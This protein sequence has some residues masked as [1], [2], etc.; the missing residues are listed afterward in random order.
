M[1]TQR[2]TVSDWWRGMLLLPWP[3]I[4]HRQIPPQLCIEFE[5][6]FE[7]QKLLG[8]TMDFS[9]P[10]DLFTASWRRKKEKRKEKRVSGP[11]T[12]VSVI[13]INGLN[14]S[15]IFKNSTINFNFWG[16]KIKSPLLELQNWT[17]KS[18]IKKNATWTWKGKGKFFVITFHYC[19]LT[20][21]LQQRQHDTS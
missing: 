7:N 3:P 2:R 15:R 20:S 8:F 1:D 16:K 13:R 19:I 9:R 5:F 21:S 6:E 17:K 14:S 10:R 4:S 11:W 18:K 12:Y